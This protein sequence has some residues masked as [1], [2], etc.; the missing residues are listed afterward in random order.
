MSFDSEL[1]C[2][3][4]CGLGSDDLQFGFWLDAPVPAGE[5][6]HLY[7]DARNLADAA[8]SGAI[9]LKTIDFSTPSCDVGDPLATVEL[10][11]LALT[12]EWQTR[13]V[14]LTAE[15][16]FTVFGLYVTGDDFH[17]ALDAFRFGPPCHD[18]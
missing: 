9:R 11:A 15:A 4:P 14:T 10:A 2:S 3:F 18:P 5:P 7:F 13:C 17:V 16:D 1:D 8:P 6:F 12:D